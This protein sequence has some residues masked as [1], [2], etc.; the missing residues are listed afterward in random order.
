LSLGALPNSVRFTVF[1]LGIGV[2][3]LLLAAYLVSRA[4]MDLWRFIGFSLALAG[5]MSNLL[6]RLLH[7]GMVT[8]FITIHVGPLHTGVFNAA[9]ILIMLGVGVIICTSLKRTSTDAPTNQLHSSG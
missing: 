4:R 8:D 7:H 6:D 5:G 3:L 1:T 2:G 9:D